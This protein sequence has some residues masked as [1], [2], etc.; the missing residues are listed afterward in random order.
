M[1]KLI[2]FAVIALVAIVSGHSNSTEKTTSPTQTTTSTGNPTSTEKSTF[3]EKP[4]TPERSS[5]PENPKS[6]PNDEAIK[7]QWA[8]YK[9]KHCNNFILFF[10]FV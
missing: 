4:T 9:T 1:Q 7:K 5:S 6:G 2:L 3:S 8:T 10:H